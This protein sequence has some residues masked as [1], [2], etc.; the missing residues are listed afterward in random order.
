MG[1]TDN[2]SL[3]YFPL[4]FVLH[5]AEEPLQDLT[6]YAPRGAKG[7]KIQILQKYCI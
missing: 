7:M 1:R 5:L 3:E 2:C 4:Q 6:Q